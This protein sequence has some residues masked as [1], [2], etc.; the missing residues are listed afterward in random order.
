MKVLVACEYSGVVREAFSKEGHN[1]LSADFNP[2]Y[3]NNI[4]HY[5]GD[6]F[7]LIDIFHFDL[8]IA[9]PPCTY[10]CSSGMHWTKRGFRDYKLTQDALFFVWELMQAPI[11][12]IAIENPIGIISSKI[13]KPDQII[14]PYEF[15][16]NSS[17]KTCLWLKGLPLLKS[18]EYVEPRIVVDGFKKPR[19]RWGNQCDSGQNKLTPSPDRWKVRSV[20]YSGIAKAMALQWGTIR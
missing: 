7:D 12:L 19:L 8:M 17:K 9:H 5:I 18:T 4:N 16:E 10:L 1:V 11:E 13:R 3:D 20:T 2:S 15:G 14:Q 6:C